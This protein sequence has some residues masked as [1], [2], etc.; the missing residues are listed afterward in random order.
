MT[1]A[2]TGQR[3]LT[4]AALISRALLALLIC[5]AFALYLYGQLSKVRE[6]YDRDSAQQAVAQ[7]AETIQSE[8]AQAMQ[9]QSSVEL[10]DAGVSLNAAIPLALSTEIIRP[11]D[12][13]DLQERYNFVV[14]DMVN[15][16][17][18]GEAVVPE[19]VRRG[20][21]TEIFWAT[22]TPEGVL[23]VRY[24]EDW[25]TRLADSVRGTT[26]GIR[27]VQTL[28][29]NTREGITLFS[30]G[31]PDPE[32]PLASR[33]IHSVWHISY[34]GAA[35]RPG[36]DAITLLMPW[37]GMMILVAIAVLVT[38]AV[39]IRQLRLPIAEAPTLR[40]VRATPVAT[41]ASPKNHHELPYADE[42]VGH[43]VDLPDVEEPPEEPEAAPPPERQVSVQD[44]PVPQ[45]IFRAYDIRGLV[46]TE[47]T[48]DT[49]VLLGRAIGSEV[50]ARGGERINLAWDGRL[51]SQR[52]ANHLQEGLLNSGCSVNR[53]GM[54]PTGALYWATEEL[55]T[56][57]GVMI[58]GS[59][60]PIEYNG[61]KIVM[62]GLPMAEDELLSLWYRIQREEF[63]TGYAGARNDDIYSD[64]I[65]RIEDDIQINRD[66]TIVL[67]AGNGVAG[68]M[69]VD[70][71]RELGA[72]VIEL[73]CDVDGH[74]P[75]HHPDP[76]EEENLEYLRKSVLSNG[77]DLG[78]AFD[79]DGDRV[80]VLDNEGNVIWPDR[81][82]MLLIEDILPRKPG[83][84]VIFDVKSSRHLAPL[85]NRLGGRPTM[86]KTG[87][88]LMKRKLKELKASVGGEFSGHFYIGERW[89]GFDCGLYAGARIVEIL[90]SRNAS[91]A[92]VFAALPEDVSTA[93]ITINTTEDRKFSLITQLAED[94]ELRS[95]AV[96]HETDG[97]RIEYP[98]GWGLIRASNTTPRLTLRFAGDRPETI[99]RIQGTMKQALTRYAPD[100]QIPF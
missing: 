70:L 20:N 45:H 55:D 74:F 72:D 47:L 19:A 1:H 40:P 36:P 65:E 51:S 15:Q 2:T 54:L 7:L 5:A 48:N 88:S 4:S 18:Q 71:F 33:R 87:H 100:I 10:N 21:S 73:F 77:A 91:A 99:E 85:I 90:S 82:L 80:A 24:G 26:G 38:L 95:G 22:P 86:W 41:Q 49:L 84:D 97:L 61:L 78:L 93:E 17:S 67:D 56:R 12:A 46:D 16:V 89:Y 60:N 9:A 66:L 92:E 94:S 39:L 63:S 34:Q 32:A 29:G 98:D 37:G 76:G 43:Q 52:L 27:L 69:A 83:S 6:A 23:L 57:H 79:G 25:I 81:L 30:I 11:E 35:D 53:L 75:N 96:V 8:I 31:S 44:C 28:T 64:Y 68:P 59:H 13:Q 3:T 14:Q 58:T 50:R 42:T 62:D